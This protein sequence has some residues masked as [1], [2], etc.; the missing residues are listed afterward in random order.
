MQLVL[1][2]SALSLVPQ[3]LQ[4]FCDRHSTAATGSGS[5]GD[6]KSDIVLRNDNGQIEFRLMDGVNFTAYC[7]L[8]LPDTWQVFTKMDWLSG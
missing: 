6:G 7:D 2:R 3:L 4:K 1:S 8:S 5:I